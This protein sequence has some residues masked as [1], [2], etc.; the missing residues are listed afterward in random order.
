[1]K[2]LGEFI[3][4]LES[5]IKELPIEAENI[6]VE[7]ALNQKGYVVRRIQS[8]GIPGES[9]SEKGVPAYLYSNDKWS[10]SYARKNSGFD[11]MIKNKKKS[12]ELVS[13]K[14][15]REANG[16][17]TNFVDFTFTGRTFQN[18]K[19]VSIE[20]SGFVAKAYLGSDNPE[21]SQRLFYGFKLY[22]DFL[23]PN[24]DEKR[25][26]NGIANK[27]LDKVFEKIKL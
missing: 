13:W 7:M 4:K 27:M 12:G 23:Y 6:A 9:Y 25:F 26:L 24:E 16:H 18:L 19:V 22:G 20:R 8:E 21:V 10:N 3:A 1:M 15:V 11:R 14:D 17:Q 5:V 2:E